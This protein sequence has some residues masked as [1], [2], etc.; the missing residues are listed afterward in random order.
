LCCA[1]GSGAIAAAPGW[2]AGLRAGVAATASGNI[3]FT[4]V[5]RSRFL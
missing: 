4:R 3:G 5:R 2:R 1:D